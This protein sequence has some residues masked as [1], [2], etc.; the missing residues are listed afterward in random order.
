MDLFNPSLYWFVGGIILFFLEMAV[1][2]F[3]LFFFGVGACLTALATL[4]FGL[5]LNGQLLVFIIASLLSLIFLRRYV[6]KAFIGKTDFSGE[7]SVLAEHGTQVE[8]VSDIVPPN[9]GKVKYSGTTWR[10]RAT[11]KIRT[12]EIVTIIEQD[13]LIMTVRKLEDS[14]K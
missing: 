12:G 1:P 4:L 5:S 8:V 9:E 11:E 13:G 10:A 3:V 14:K 7:D 2:G 6:Q